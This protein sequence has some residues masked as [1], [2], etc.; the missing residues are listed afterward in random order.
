MH[1]VMRALVLVPLFFAIAWSGL[2]LDYTVLRNNFYC[3]LL[4][5]SS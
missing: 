1:F 4:L 5:H 2:T 3:D